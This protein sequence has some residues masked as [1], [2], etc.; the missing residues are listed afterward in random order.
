MKNEL[1]KEAT[2]QQRTAIAEL[3]RRLYASYPQQ[4]ASTI[5]YGSVA[6][7]DFTPDS[8]IDVLIIADEADAD[9]KWGVRG[10]GSRVSFEF[11]VIFNLHIYSRAA[12]DLQRASHK[13]LWRNVERDG[14]PFSLQSLPVAG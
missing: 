5:L 13:T 14:I 3:L 1:P 4:I 10:I 7:G 12:W 9:F 11:D 2:H 6:R 8:D